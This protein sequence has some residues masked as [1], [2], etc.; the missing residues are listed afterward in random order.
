TGN[1]TVG[2]IML[3][4]DNAVIPAGEE[5]IGTLAPGASKTVE[6]SHAITHADLD[7]GGVDN[8]AS[9]SGT[10]PVGDPVNSSSDDPS[11]PDSDDPTR[12]ELTQSLAITITK[13]TRPG[14]FVQVGD[15]IVYDLVVTNTGNVTLTNIEI[16]DEN[17]DAGSLPP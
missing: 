11:T 2:N 15:V 4:D 17:A 6:V 1:V 9:V 12:A 14:E 10:D 13:R 3:T 16:S 5:N 7:N 8:Q